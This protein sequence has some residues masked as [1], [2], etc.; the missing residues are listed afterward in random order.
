MPKYKVT[1]PASGRTVTLNGESP[2]TEQELEEV[3][4]SL[5]SSQ[6]AQ[7]APQ[8]QIVTAEDVPVA[9]GISA[10][11]AVIQE[12]PKLSITDKT[13]GVG[14][15]GL[16]LLSGA[17]GGLYGNIE[18]AVKGIGNSVLSGRFGTQEGANQ[19]RQQAE[20]SAASLTYS[21]R[22]LAGQQYLQKAG[23]A[24]SPLAGLAPFT[25]EA[26]I[27]GRT[28]PMAIKE[29]SRAPAKVVDRYAEKSISAEAAPTIDALKEASR[30]IYKEIDD[31][32]AVVS[33]DQV[34]SLSNDIYNTVRNE[35]FNKKIHPAVSAALDEFEEAAKYDQPITNIDTL[36]K[37]ASN[38]AGSMDRSEARLGKLVINKID[39]FL[40]NLDE[41]ALVGGD[42]IEIGSKYR[43]A[44]QL[45]QRA[46]K[47]EVIDKAISKAKNQASGFENGLRVQFR[48]ILNNDKKSR[49]FTPE[50]RAA[51]EKVVQ[52]GGVENAAKLVGK[53]GFGEGQATNMLM[54]SLG[55]GAGAAVGGPAG[56]VAVPLIGQVSRGLAQKLT[57]NNAE[58]VSQIVRSGKDAT[59]ITRAYLAATPANKRSAMDL[60]ELLLKMGAKDKIKIDTKD[61]ELKTILSDTDYLLGLAAAQSSQTNREEKQ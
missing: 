5:S 51:M 50:E 46:T 59:G 25:Q 6:V 45:W 20:D 16:S 41:S 36:R 52:G 33:K 1:D 30:G 34:Q 22:T 29:I 47:A 13:I 37:V 55:A 42:S 61:P 57:R 35:G 54:G 28:A 18:G 24:L 53:L 17:T 11:P 7:V 44:R 19:A 38:A 12:Q 43:D 48:S 32:G 10:K 23:E 2:P 9:P 60:S 26:A 27:V 56:A 21:P 39:G 49:S 14:E 3:F 8:T 15:A 4:S 58:M 40:D 31:A